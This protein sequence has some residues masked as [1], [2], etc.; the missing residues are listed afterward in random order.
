MRPWIKLSVL[1]VLLALPLCGQKLARIKAEEKKWDRINNTRFIEDEQTR[2]L[3]KDFRL[4]RMVHVQSNHFLVHWDIEQIK[5]GRRIYKRRDAARLY[6]RRLEE[7]LRDWKKIFGEPNRLPS[8][9]HWTV[10]ILGR[11]RDLKRVRATITTGAQKLFSSQEPLFITGM[12][13]AELNNDEALHANV[14]HHTSHLITEIGFPYGKA[15]PAGWFTIGVAH[16]LEIQKFGET[17]NFTTGEVATARDRWQMGKWPKKVFS[18]VRKGKAP[19]LTSFSRRAGKK[20]NPMLA[21]FSW[22]MV[23][24]IIVT[25]PKLRGDFAR[26]LARGVSTEDAMRQ[27]FGW[28]LSRFQEEWEKFCTKN[29][30]RSGMPPKKKK[31]R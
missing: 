23:D 8:S 18:V 6:S 24:F 3:N 19:R 30:G 10:W 29:Q 5:V 26:M 11:D 17:R 22:S 27:L 7:L 13:R 31:R 1:F 14:Y 12:N 16:W 21:A 25:R 20:V 15:E 2:K 4:P 9:G 28:S